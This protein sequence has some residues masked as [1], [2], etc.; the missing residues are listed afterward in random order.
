MKN[1][2]LMFG[3]FVLLAAIAA[4]IAAGSLSRA[5]G[6]SQVAIASINIAADD[7]ATV[8]NIGDAKIPQAAVQP[9][10][11][12]SLQDL[13]GMAAKGFIPA[14]TVL[15]K[16]MFQNISMA[17]AEAKLSLEP[18]LIAVALPVSLDTTIGGEIK[19]GSHVDIDVVTKEGALVTVAG[20][21]EVLTIPDLTQTSNTGKGVVLG[22]QKSVADQMVTLEKS[23]G[24]VVL[25][26]LPSAG[27]AGEQS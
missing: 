27:S 2:R 19:A 23:N 8:K 15:R 17:G 21:V 5:T 12:L 25:E 22:M 9:D 26:L 3:L 7:A 24:N 10:T 11:A 4:I 20:N 6:T 18:D 1:Y 14:G 13:Q 16:S